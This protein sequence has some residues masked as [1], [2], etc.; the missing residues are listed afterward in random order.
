MEKC[1]IK[2]NKINK[3]DKHRKNKSFDFSKNFDRTGY[4]FKKENLTNENFYLLDNKLKST[5]TIKSKFLS[6][7]S[8]G[9]Y[10]PYNNNNI[11]NSNSY[12]DK[13]NEKEKEKNSSS[14]SNSNIAR[15][16]G[17]NFYLNQFHKK[18]EFENPYSPIDIYRKNSNEI[19]INYKYNSNEE[20]IIDP[21][22]KK[23]FQEDNEF[24]K[25]EINLSLH[26]KKKEENK[27]KV[28]INREDL[29][30]K[31]PIRSFNVIWKNKI[32][33]E[34]MTKNV[35]SRQKNFY[36]EFIKKINDY[37]NFK[38][39]CVKKL[40]V[41]N[42]VAKKNLYEDSNSNSNTYSNNKNEDDNIN[43]K[44]N[45]DSKKDKKNENKIEN[46]FIKISPKGKKK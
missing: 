39:S 7:T 3:M 9:F 10:N 25:F 24:K 41:T 4:K 28:S 43:S 26:K 34:N 42:I 22:E 29:D 16:T 15:K 27:L 6:T 36:E 33:H 44:N 30:F 32:I 1:Y 12:F 38:S 17:Q 19:L 20:N 14:N 23:L 40:K 37:E 13:E 46:K 45:N 5:Q 21:I 8:S 18:Y 2:I 11:R 31:S 35:I